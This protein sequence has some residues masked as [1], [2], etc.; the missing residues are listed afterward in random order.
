M[1][2]IKYDIIVIG[3]GGGANIVK[4]ARRKGLK[5]AIVEKSR[6]GGTCLNRGCIP[7]KMLIHPADIATEINESK[8]FDINAK[9]NSINFKKLVSRIS[10]TVDSESESISKNYKKIENIDFYHMEG[11][12]ESDKVIKVGRKRITSNKIVIATGA[13]P[14]VPP[15]PG[16]KDTPYWTSTDALRSEKLPKKLIV[17]G[18]GYIAVELG[19]AYSALGSDVSFL[20]RGPMVSREDKEV[21]ETFNRV[22]KE[23]HD[24]ID[25]NTIENVSYKGKEFTLTYTSSENKKK[26]IK[27]D[28]VLV[29]T[30]VV[31]NTDNL[32]LENTKIKTNKFGF[33]QVDKYLETPIKG[34][35][36]IGDCVG[37]Y[38]FR[39]SVNFE[40]EYLNP[41]LLHKAKK[42][43]IKYV[44]IPHSIFTNPQIA[45]VGLTE[46][47]LKEKKVPYVV[48]FNKY[49]NSAMGMAILEEDGFVKLLFH[50]KTKKLLGAHII[51]PESSNMIHMLIYAIT[52]N[53]TVDT[54]LKMVYVHPALPEIVRNAVRNAKTQF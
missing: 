51:G 18:G 27:G 3:G 8:K 10:N 42:V 44:P 29:A 36:A 22:F 30:G 12:F 31:P 54:L 45:G 39:H 16:L 11:K 48:G 34:V 13:R 46:Q 15:I 47:E 19:Y 24:V 53:A 14:M 38:L 7:S 50:K 40:T 2:I 5:V 35:Y 17:I 49:K 43:P 23:K 20:V 32:G 9:F 52:F 4:E 25:I 37:N 6:L 28:A 1:N 33:I 26:S 21:I 41:I